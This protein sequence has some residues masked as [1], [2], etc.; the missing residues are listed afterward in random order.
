M[1]E[2]DPRLV[3][4]DLDGTLLNRQGRVSDRVGRALRMARGRGWTLVLATGRPWATTRT[5][6]GQC[7][8]LGDCWA[9]CADGALLYGPGEEKPAYRRLIDG[10]ALAGLTVDLPDLLLVAE[11]QSGIYLGTEELPAGEFAGTQQTAGWEV[12][13]EVAAPRLY[14]RTAHADVA[15]LRRRL[16]EPRLFTPVVYSRDGYTWADLTAAGVSKASTLE[17]LRARLG[18]PAAATIAVGDSW[19]DIGMLRW[20]NLG[21]ATGDAASEVVAAADIVIP[22]CADDGVAVLLECEAGG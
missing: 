1:S 18:I 10:R 2:P 15:D 14:L 19:N 21:A 8:D 16:E 3:A 22:S 20:A 17:F 6:A 9:V 12:V 4:L 5:V 13:C 7:A 11:Q